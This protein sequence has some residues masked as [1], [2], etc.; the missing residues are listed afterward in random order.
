MGVRAS[1][2]QGET[3]LRILSNNQVR[4]PRRCAGTSNSAIWTTRV[5]GTTG[6]S[7]TSSTKWRQLQRPTPPCMTDPT[8][9]TAQGV[10]TRRRS[11]LAL[12]PG[13]P[14]PASCNLMTSK[15]YTTK[16]SPSGPAAKIRRKKTVILEARRRSRSLRPLRA[17]PG[18]IFSAAGARGARLNAGSAPPQKASKRCPQASRWVWQERCYQ[19]DGQRCH[20]APRRQTSSGGHGLHR[21]DTAA[22]AA[23]ELH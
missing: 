20:N 18:G 14:E 10:T 17:P 21:D 13:S 16:S 11:Y 19:D 8:V 1:R 12:V 4:A 2:R 3:V 23:P 6:P 9:S 22:P 5:T 15:N 7:Q